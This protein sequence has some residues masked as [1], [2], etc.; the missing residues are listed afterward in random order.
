MFYKDTECISIDSVVE[1]PCC[2]GICIL[3]ILPFSFCNSI[4]PLFFHVFC[5]LFCIIHSIAAWN[6]ECTYLKRF[7]LASMVKLPSILLFDFLSIFFFSFYIYN[8]QRRLTE[9]LFSLNSA[10]ICLFP[11]LHVLILKWLLVLLLRIFHDTETLSQLPAENDV[12]V[13]PYL[14]LWKILECI[15]IKQQKYT[16]LVINH[17]WG[18]EKWIMKLKITCH[19]FFPFY[20]TLLKSLLFLPSCWYLVS[21]RFNGLS[22]YIKI[23][24]L[25][26]LD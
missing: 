20:P 22:F 4:H 26:V 15:L 18:Q 6:K 2:L 9:A 10:L 24:F 17:C 11:S 16:L 25:S 14:C 21:F 1:T 12:S 5:L 13:L 3:K 23:M 19:D 8:F 7:D